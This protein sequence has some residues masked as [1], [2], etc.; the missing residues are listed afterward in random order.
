MDNGVPQA[1][2]LLY[3][4]STSLGNRINSLNI[5]WKT[6]ANLLKSGDVN[7]NLKFEDR[8]NERFLE[9]MKLC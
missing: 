3:N 8:Q 7:H 4:I 6:K 1:E 2:D 9:A 5:D